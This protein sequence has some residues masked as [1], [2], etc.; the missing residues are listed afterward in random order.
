MK[1]KKIAPLVGGDGAW[2][3]NVEVRG[4]A[5]VIRGRGGASVEARKGAIWI[6]RP[7]GRKC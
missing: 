1:M 5:L 4:G 2:I 6:W 3:L 7:S